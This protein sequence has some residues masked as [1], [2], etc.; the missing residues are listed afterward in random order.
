MRTGNSSA[1]LRGNGGVD[2]GPWRRERGN[3]TI[4]GVAEQ[5]SLMRLDRRAQHFVMRNQRRPHRSR[6]GFPPTG[7]T[8]D[9]GEQK[10][11]D[12][13][14]RAPRWH[15]HRISQNAR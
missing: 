11:H 6:V 13:R 7:R 8:L 3:H 2:G 10:R 5:E 4:P 14:R 12:P 9:I 15:P 1:G